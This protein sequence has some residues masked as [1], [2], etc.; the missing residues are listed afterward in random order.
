MV[1]LEDNFKIIWQNNPIAIITPGKD[2][3][4]PKIEIIADDIIEL[5]DKKKLIEFLNN[6]LEDKIKETLKN[7]FDLKLINEK[8]SNIRAL[9]YQLYENNGV[10]KRSE[11]ADLIKKLNNED[12]KVLRKYGVKFGRY[13]IFLFKLFKPDSVKLR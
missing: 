6:W 12:R 1:I 8:N 5:E 11:S 10:V 13:H 3:L 4:S 9:A 7:L 2:Y